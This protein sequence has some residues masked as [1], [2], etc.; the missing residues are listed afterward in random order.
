MPLERSHHLRTV[1]SAALCASS[2]LRHEDTS[3]MQ[4][5]AS[6]ALSVDGGTRSERW[7]ARSTTSASTMKPATT[8]HKMSK[9]STYR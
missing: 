8:A 1:C 2:R 4:P 3:A 7:M 9:I 6:F 5:V